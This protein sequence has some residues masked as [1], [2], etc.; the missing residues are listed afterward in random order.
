MGGST[1][2]KKN[3]KDFYKIQKRVHLNTMFVYNNAKKR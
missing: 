2:K 3:T 1:T